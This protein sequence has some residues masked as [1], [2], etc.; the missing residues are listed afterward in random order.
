M[1]FGRETTYFRKGY[2]LDLPQQVV[3]DYPFDDGYR[4]MPNL[5]EA[6]RELDEEHDE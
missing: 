4:A 2:I 3:T 5:E 1:S 6:L